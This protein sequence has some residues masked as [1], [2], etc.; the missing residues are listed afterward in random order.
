MTE[1]TGPTECPGCRAEVELLI[2]QAE[3]Y[4][5]KPIG[6]FSLSGHQMKVSAVKADV[7]SLTHD[8][9]DCGWTG[10]VLG[11][12]EDGETLRIVELEPSRRKP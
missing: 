1:R 8:T 10:A 11:Y 3:M 2:G 4:A 12:K 9:D 6:D 5:S 7:P